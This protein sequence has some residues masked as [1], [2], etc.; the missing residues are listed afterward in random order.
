MA[1]DYGQSIQLPN[2]EFPRRAGL[3]KKEPEILKRWQGM[4]LYKRQRDVA[5]GRKKFILH[6]GP[7]FANGHTH[8]GHALSTV[9][10][11]V[12]TKSYQMMGYD[13]PLVPGFD[14]HGL[15][16]E[17]KIEEKYRKEKKEKED[18]DPLQFRTECREFAR[19]WLDIQ[20]GEFERMGILGDW[21]DPYLT[22]NKRSE[23]LIAQEIHKFLLKGALYRGSKP[24]MWSI[25]E[26][27]ALAEA[28]IE[29]QDITSDTVWVKFPVKSVGKSG[30]AEALADMAAV[31]WTTTPWTL[32][33][34]RAVAYGDDIDY[35]GIEV[36]TLGDDSLATVGDKLIIAKDLYDT[37]L[38]DTK[39]AEAKVV[40]EGKGTEL[41]GVTCHHPLASM[42]GYELDIPLLSGHHVTT[43]SG[44]GLVH[45]APSHGE[46]DYQIGLKYDLQIPHTVGAD[47]IYTDQAP[48]FTGAS[49]YTSEGKK[50][51][52]NKFVTGR[53]GEF[54]NLVAKSQI[55]H[56][57]PHS[58]RS[59]SPIIFR[60]TPQW[61]INVE[62]NDLREKA[63]AEI[64]KVRFVPEKGEK[65]IA[66]MVEGRG[67]WCVSRQRSWGVP[68]AIFVNKETQEPLKDEAVLKRIID[69]FLEEGSDAWFDRTPQEF[70]GDDYNA[71]DYEQIV[72]IIDVWFESGSTHAFVLE[73]REEL[74]SP[75]D[76]YLE[77]SDQH[78]GWFQS[79]LLESVYTR[80]TAPY[81]AVLTHGFI[82][83]EKG[84]KMAKSGTNGVS[85]NDL[86]QEFG[87]DIVRLWVVG[88]NYTEDIRFGR[89]ILKG[90]TDIYRRVRN[91]FCY[92]L[93]N[94]SDFNA[95][96]DAVAYSDLGEFDR[97]ALHKVSELDAYVRDC[98]ENFEFLK[99]ITALHTFCSKDLSAFY[100]DVNKDNL[101]CN[102]QSSQT[103]R[104]TQTVLD[105]IF[106]HLCHWFSPVLS[107]TC[108]EAWLFYHGK[109]LNDGEL[110]IHL[111]KFPEAPAEWKDDVLAERWKNIY[112]VR[113]VVMGAI[114]IKRAAKEVRSSL[115]ASPIVYVTDKA[116]YQNLENLDFADVCI[117]SSIKFLGEAAP[118]GAFTVDD[119]PSVA[120]ALDMA[121]GD[122]CDRCWKYTTDIGQDTEHPSICGRCS[123]AIDGVVLEAVAEAS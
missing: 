43:E 27:T 104:A 116:I 28:E 121:K 81:K 91:T 62:H 73:E 89:N 4:D 123:E 19:H 48:G 119:I 64:K 97:W 22:M 59:K 39:V 92:L 6:M 107:Y 9:L 57:Y 50:G 49:V 63:L 110:S 99:M 44:T 101:Y 120:V 25:P 35:V 12:V 90:H 84:Y 10:K 23:A 20:T 96:T 42:E 115:E 24:V 51:P 26:K 86:M 77:G 8:M 102:G 13:A 15:P 11:D 32:P 71:D 118:E 2:T 113:R 66:S 74:R 79:S 80:G 55:R 5:K 29:Y 36:V 100:F 112:D 21:K 94:L 45:I 67:D 87:A 122:K 33:A 7:P 60:N 18:V 78:R 76:L 40:W 16:I 98:I 114:E 69:V 103:R 56:S 53:I 95:E 82:L 85:P 34:N 61:F 68:I 47:G 111:S 1:F 75:A 54:G 14:C 105:I 17:W 65:R 41:A 106:K 52:A 117:T 58:W 72:D 93:G 83:D 70:L 38:S 109:D 31:I 3:A 30:G 88:S 46:D 37:F 108:E